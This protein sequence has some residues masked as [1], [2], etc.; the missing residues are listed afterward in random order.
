MLQIPGLGRPFCAHRPHTHLVT[1]KLER[2]LVS[3]EMI[4]E[5]WHNRLSSSF[6][7][8]MQAH[9]HAQLMHTHTRTHICTAH[10]HTHMNTHAP[11]YVHMSLCTHSSSHAHKFICTQLMHTHVQLK[12]THICPHPCT[13]VHMHS[14]LHTHTYTHT[15]NH[16]ILLT[17][18]LRKHS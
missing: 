17:E 10:V 6:H 4:P 13:H 7:T 12:Y 11:A 2:D 3:K 5:Q 16:R 9:T 8:Q 18:D 15:P 14:H 1:S